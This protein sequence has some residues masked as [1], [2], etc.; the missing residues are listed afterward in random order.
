M[1]SAIFYDQDGVERA[2]LLEEPIT[3]E[4][5][6]SITIGLNFG[7]LLMAHGILPGHSNGGRSYV[8]LDWSADKKVITPRIGTTVAFIKYSGPPF[9]VNDGIIPNFGFVT[10]EIQATITVSTTVLEEK[11]KKSRRD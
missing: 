8:L 10:W 6:K 4:A 5:L 7:T 9:F 1:N 3:I 2:E 11:R